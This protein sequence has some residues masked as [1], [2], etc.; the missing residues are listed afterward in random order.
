M[1]FSEWVVVLMVMAV[2]LSFVGI[3]T[4]ITTVMEYYGVNI[5][6]S[7]L[8]SADVENSSLWDYL[9]NSTTGKL[10]IV[11]VAGVVIGLFAKS[12]DTSLVILPIIVS[13]VILFIGIF[14]STIAYVMDF[15]QNWLTMII[16]LILIGML[17]GFIWSAVDHFAGR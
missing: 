15:G 12:Y 7:E 3:P 5:T 6:S 2:F 4:G 8:I 16:G 14:W 17:M 13:Q 11:A 10:A 1:K 9:F